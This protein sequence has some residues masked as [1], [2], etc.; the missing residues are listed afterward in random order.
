MHDLVALLPMKARSERI[1]NKNFREFNGKMLFQWILDTLLSIEEIERVVI[2]TDARGVLEGKGLKD[3]PRVLIRDRK[4]EI[5]GE[6]ISMNRVLAD[7][8]E[9][10]EA[11]TYLMTHTTN[12]LLGADTIRR[13][14]NQ[15]QRSLD[16]R[17][18]SLFAVNKVQS[19]FYREDGSAVNH[20]PSNLL[21][22][23][24]LEPWF[25]ENSLLYLFSRQ[26][27][28]KTGSRIGST[29]YMFEIPKIESMDIDDQEDWMIAEAV[30]F[31]VNRK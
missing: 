19:R 12:P 30:S 16:H 2:N 18:D 23:Q 5:C 29:P 9:H 7:D 27:F 4:P 3:S 25:E 22:T 14:M 21:R 20:D 6:L 15:Y 31:Y 24:N 17:F 28:R 1:E 26:S 11:R 8:V 10:V 13:A